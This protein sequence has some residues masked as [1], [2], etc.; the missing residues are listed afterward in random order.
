MIAGNCTDA[1]G[2][3]NPHA[4]AT[5]ARSSRAPNEVLTAVLL[6]ADGRARKGGQGARLRRTLARAAA[7]Y[8]VE[9]AAASLRSR[10]T[11]GAS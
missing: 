8:S 6:Y 3:R 2:R 7:R 10:P 1:A 5:W 4:W 11:G 9:E